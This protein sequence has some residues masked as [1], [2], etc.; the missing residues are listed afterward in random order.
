MAPNYEKAAKILSEDKNII[1]LAKVDATFELE[2]SEKYNIAGY[3]TLLVFRRGRHYE[4]Q[5]GRG[6][7]GK[8]ILCLVK[9]SNY[10]SIKI[11]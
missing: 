1:P 5:G 8:N 3:P 10:I 9:N 7:N 4:Y 11:L 2:L 6:V